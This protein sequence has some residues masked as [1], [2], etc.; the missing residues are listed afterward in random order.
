MS[1]PLDP[2]K[3]AY[4][5]SAIA[6][7][8]IGRA[9]RRTVRITHLKL[10]KLVYISYGWGLA[11]LGGRRLFH[12]P[13]EAWRLGPVIPPLYHEFKRF[14]RNSIDE[15]SRHYSYEKQRF[16]FPLVEDDDI[17]ALRVLNLTWDRYGTRPGEALSALTH[18]QGTPWSRT[19][20]GAQIKDELI[21]RHFLY[22]LLA[23]RKRSLGR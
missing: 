17:G 16:V 8:M 5:V 12:E 23:E 7:F 13:I 11:R 21:R 4:S 3:N 15:W 6:N 2:G 14:G 18:Q 1:G 10:Q 22:L 9:K 20:R 19:P